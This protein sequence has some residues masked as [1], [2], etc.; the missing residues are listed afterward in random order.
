MSA[1]ST[2]SPIV[3]RSAR[4]SSSIACADVDDESSGTNAPSRTSPAASSA[5]IPA[6]ARG[7]VEQA[8]HRWTSEER[9]RD[10]HRDERDE[11]AVVDDPRL[12]REKGEEDFHR[13]SRVEPEPDSERL[14][15]RQSGE[16]R[17]AGAPDELG[18]RR[19][20]EDDEAQ[21]GIEA[22]DEVDVQGDGREE[23]G[24]EDVGDELVDRLARPLA[25][26]R[27]VAEC[28][29]DDEAAEDGV[30]ADRLGDGGA[31]HGD[32]GDERE[33]ASGRELAVLLDC[34]EDAV[35]D[36]PPGDQADEREPGGEHDGANEDAEL[37]PAAVHRTEEDAE[38]D[39]PDEI[40]EH[41]D[42]HHEQ[43]DVRLEEPE[44]R[45]VSS[46]PPAA[47]RSRARRP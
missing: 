20:E 47:P 15:P 1:G 42:R 4:P 46:R 38:R 25:K 26:A 13:A 32:D 37:D 18:R 3:G 36:A 9:R 40:V 33:D 16:A 2:R 10:G 27:R 14:P 43:A 6:A 29:P 11:H 28:D 8:L 44:I 12:A 21:H 45:G 23:D 31:E 24:G 35:D 5:L 41:R 22:R 39:P 19:D 17:A 34:G 30:D 7:R